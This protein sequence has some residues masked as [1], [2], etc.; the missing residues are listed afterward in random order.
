MP[1]PQ[2]QAYRV[3][4]RTRAVPVS[5]TVMAE[6]VAA[7]NAPPAGPEQIQPQPEADGGEIVEG[8]DGGGEYCASC[9]G[10]GGG[11]GCDGGAGGYDDC[12]GGA[13]YGG[14]CCPWL[15]LEPG[16]LW[17]RG[18]SLLWWTKGVHV[19]EL[20]TTSDNNTSYD[21]AGQLGLSTT[22][23]LFGNQDVNGSSRPGGRIS[24][25]LRPTECTPWGVEATYFQLGND[26]TRYDISSTGYPILA[27]P[28]YNL[29]LST[30]S[31]S[32]DAN[33]LAFRNT[34]GVVQTGDVHVA[35]DTRLYGVEV[36][37]RRQLYNL[38]TSQL[39][40]LAGWRYMQLR[41]SLAISSHTDVV[42]PQDILDVDAGTTIDVLD[43]FQTQNLFNGGEIGLVASTQ[44]CRWSLEAMMKVA[45]GNTRSRVALS[46]STVTTDPAGEATTTASGLLVLPSNS[47]ILQRDAFTM[48][49]EFGLTVG[50]DLTC[51]LRATMGYSIMY[52]GKVARAG[53]QINLDINPTQVDTLTGA[54]RP[55]MPFVT[56]D[57]WAQ[58]MNFGLEYHF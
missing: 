45:I 42:D 33:V 31:G 16:R 55:N 51:R 2:R 9:G 39:D 12:Y 19:P 34:T 6:P 29:S 37:F 3:P 28:F 22:H 47:G 11:C 4:Q 8:P 23:L 49:P 20:V 27:R 18:E 25:G 17:V 56:N 57:F 41:D 43:Q 54:A 38:C 46:G 32:G 10:Y 5:Q 53:D 52:W 58:G 35:A 15:G 1:L 13:C 40:L 36:L 44:F 7:G 24:F 48:I 21:R 30:T 26:V 14:Q 50:Y